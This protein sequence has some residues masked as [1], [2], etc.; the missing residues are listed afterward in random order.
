MVPCVRG[1]L[2]LM[3]SFSSFLAYPPP[4]CGRF[5][6]L[7]TLASSWKELYFSISLD[8]KAAFLAR[9]MGDGI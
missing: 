2:T 1:L 5:Y 7:P 8:L 9:W 3:F 6:P 4:H